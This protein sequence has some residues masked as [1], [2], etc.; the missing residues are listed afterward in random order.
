[1]GHAFLLLLPLTAFAVGGLFLR[2]RHALA[3][4]VSTASAL[5][6]AAWATW[7]AWAK[8][9]PAAGAV[10]LDAGGF[11]VVF[12]LEWDALARLMAAVVTWVGAAIHVYSWGYMRGDPG[13]GRFFAF[14]SLFM[15]SMLGIVLAGNLVMMYVFWE[16]VGLSSYLLIGFWHERASAADAGKKAFIVNKLGDFG[17][18][19]GI[20]VVWTVLGT[21]DFLDLQAAAPTFRDRLA[22]SPLGF[23]PLGAVALLLFCGAVGKSAQFPLHVWLPDAMEGPTPV[24]ALIHAATMVAAGVYML[25]RLFFLF[26]LSPVALEAIAWTGGLTALLAALW[27]VAQDDIKRVLAYSTLSQLGYMVMAVG[28]ASP[29]AAMFHLSTHAAFKALLFL[30]AGSVIVALH[31]E[32]DLW[33]MGGL[34]NRMRWTSVAFLV[35]M[36][37]LCGVPFFAGAAS[38]DGILLVALRENRALFALGAFTA[39]LTSLYMG[40]LFVAAFLGA[41]RGEAAARATENGWVMKGPLAVLALFSFAFAWRGGWAHDC[42]ATLVGAPMEHAPAVVH[43]FF[44]LIPLCGLLGAW[45]L[46]REKPTDA[47][48]QLFPGLRRA[49]A[50][51]FLFD[52]FYLWLVRGVQE[53]FAAFLRGVDQWGVDGLGVRGVS[54]AAFCLGNV[55][56]CFHSGSLQFYGF[57]LGLATAALLIFGVLR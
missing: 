51:K 26:A 4:T 12:R 8:A 28:L 55:L 49:L 32:Q 44:I 34:W 48:G 54:L 52:E 13:T 21:V 19:L 29:H 6:S 39:L 27:T 35:G 10:W 45:A 2:R 38:K 36:L 22:A 7:L 17:F 1:M 20:L 41:P 25:C 47:L 16:L 9:D 5:A 57:L 18:L 11:T 3:A 53:R 37:A 56:R 42:L 50:S 31:H 14:L 23:L 30:G 43:A 33:R 24:S 40:R 46:Y 15:F